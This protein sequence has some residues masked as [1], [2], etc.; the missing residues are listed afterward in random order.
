M[1]VD[2]VTVMALGSE[3]ALAVMR[4]R[5]VLGRA[6][7]HARVGAL[8]LVYVRTPDGWRVAHDHTSTL[9]V[10]ESRDDYGRLLAYVWLGGVL[11]NSRSRRTCST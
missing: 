3:A 11:I 8:T 9:E 1:T 4:Y 2:S 7:R 6:N 5:W 10:V